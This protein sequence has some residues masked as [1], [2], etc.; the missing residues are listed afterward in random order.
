MLLSTNLIQPA[1][2][3]EERS[4]AWSSA[5]KR[6]QNTALERNRRIRAGGAFRKLALIAYSFVIAALRAPST[7]DNAYLQRKSVRAA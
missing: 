1:P 7:E 6:N 2:S 5:G 4:D 3:S